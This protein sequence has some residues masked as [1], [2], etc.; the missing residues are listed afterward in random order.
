MRPVRPRPGQCRPHRGQRWPPP[1]SPR[2]F[3]PKEAQL[4]GCTPPGH[5]DPRVGCRKWSR[6]WRKA[7]D[8]GQGIW[9]W[10]SGAEPLGMGLARERAPALPRVRTGPSELVTGAP[11]LHL[12]AGHSLSF[13]RKFTPR[14]WSP[15]PFEPR[16]IELPTGWV[17][18]LTG[19]SPLSPYPRPP[20]PRSALL[21][22]A[23]H[24]VPT[25]LFQLSS[26]LYWWLK[27]HTIC[28]QYRR[29]RFNAW[30]RKIPQTR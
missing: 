6:P 4:D 12:G 9:V 15:P 14:L 29:P 19:W 3:I 5:S 23:L 26:P 11:G 28:L 16:N 2:L 20:P 27:Q 25:V 13:S 8:G 21:D 7:Q 22:P 24:S 10:G 1:I 18:L 17:E 30:V